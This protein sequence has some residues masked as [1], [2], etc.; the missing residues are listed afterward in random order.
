MTIN[1]ENMVKLVENAG[2]YMQE[3]ANEIIPQDVKLTELTITIQ[4]SVD[5]RVPKVTVNSEYTPVEILRGV[6]FS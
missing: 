3:N 4:L 6:K 5:Y 2:K 1:R